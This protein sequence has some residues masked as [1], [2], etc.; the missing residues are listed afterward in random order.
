MSSPEPGR[1]PRILEVHWTF[2]PTTGGVESHLADLSRQ[3]AARGCEVTVL[4]GEPQPIASD[5][6]DVISTELLNLDRMK[7]RVHPDLNAAEKLEQQLAAIIRAK[8]AACRDY[9]SQENRSCSRSQSASLRPCPGASDRAVSGQRR[10]TCLPHFPRDLARPSA[11]G[12]GLPSLGRQFRGIRVRPAAV[13]PNAR[14]RTRA[15]PSWR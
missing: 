1:R 15:S 3:L 2:P 6:C 8:K 12:A 9:S 14:F 11:Q 10:A 4:T 5:G 13:S 7:D